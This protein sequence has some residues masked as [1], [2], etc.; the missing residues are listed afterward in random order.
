MKGK[1]PPDPERGYAV[2]AGLASLR[3]IGSGDEAVALRFGRIV[4]AN[5]EPGELALADLAL[6]A[7][8]R[9]PYGNDGPTV[10]ELTGATRNPGNQHF[11]T[12]ILADPD[13]REQKLEADRAVCVSASR[14]LPN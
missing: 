6:G 10:A 3:L 12:L 2:Y 8:P 5:L 13:G 1:I 11:Q 7:D 9:K 14:R 4:E